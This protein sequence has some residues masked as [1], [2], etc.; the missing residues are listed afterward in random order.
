MRLRI[1]L[2]VVFGSLLGLSFLYSQNAPDRVAR[3]GQMSKEAEEK[4]LAEPYKGW[5]TNGSVETGLFP[6]KSTGVS[7]EPVRKAATTFLAAL[8]NDQRAKTTFAVDDPEW[9]KWM[10]QHFYRR[11]GVS[12]E[13]MSESQREA[14][15]G[16]L[17][18][19]LSAKGLKLT[20]DIMRLNYTLGELNNN[21]FIEY[22]E[23]LYYITIMG[24]PSKDKPW[25]WQLDGHHAIINYFVM[26]D[27]VVMTPM[28]VGSEPVIAPSGKY[29]GTSIL[30]DEQNRGLEFARALTE[31]QKKK[32]VLEVSKT[33]NNNLGEAF[34][35]NVVLDYAGVPV[36]ELNPAQKKA[37]GSLIEMYVDNMDDGHARVK[38][39]E[40]RKHLDRTYFAWIG[41]MENDSVFYYRIHSPVIVIEF[42]HQ[43]P[44]NLRHLAKDPNLPNRQHIHC[45]IRTP[46]GNDY[47]KDLLRQHYAMVKHG[48]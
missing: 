4:G 42:D 32:A 46:N 39:D 14:A 47:G 9:R 44:A 7:T 16:L 22:G 13:E 38:M 24:E 11:Q 35:D 26:G 3:F 8:T 31:G 36:K 34:K 6:M 25:G 23:W 18:A 43:R 12:F 27:Q 29:K 15:F 48:N 41:G 30:Q 1:T 10:N 2:A 33:G 40:V 17:R 21:N 19:S 20:R 45:V 5:T 28:F 37:L